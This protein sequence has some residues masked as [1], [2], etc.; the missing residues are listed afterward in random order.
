MIRRPPRSTLFPYTTLFRSLVLSARISALEKVV[1]QLAVQ[2]LSGMDNAAQLVAEMRRAAIA[3]LEIAP[4]NTGGVH[5][6]PQQQEWL[7]R[8]NIQSKHQT[9]K[10]FSAVERSLS[11]S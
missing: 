2:Q 6:T 1:E 5:L 9:E 7:R 8:E 3:S 4:M 11:T 10:L